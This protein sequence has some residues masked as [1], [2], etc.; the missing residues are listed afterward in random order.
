METT[1]ILF[2]FICVYININLIKPISANELQ[3]EADRL[4]KLRSLMILL[5]SRNKLCKEKDMHVISGEEDLVRDSKFI[6]LFYKS[7]YHCARKFLGKK[8]VTMDCILNDNKAKGINVGP[9]CVFCFVE[10]ISCAHRHCSAK[11]SLNICSSGCIKCSQK[12]CESSMHTCTGFSNM[13][14]PCKENGS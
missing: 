6:S 13:P 5:S 4:K 9:T 10:F 14:L 11:C 12:H 3:K 7:L 2:F 1:K 8:V